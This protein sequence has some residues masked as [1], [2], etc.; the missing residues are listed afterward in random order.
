MSDCDHDWELGDWIDKLSCEGDYD[1][2]VTR[3]YCT[4]CGLEREAVSMRKC[5]CKQKKKEDENEYERD[6]W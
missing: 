6:L 1:I 2:W 4:I 3:E 5:N